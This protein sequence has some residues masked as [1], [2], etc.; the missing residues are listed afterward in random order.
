[1]NPRMVRHSL[2]TGTVGMELCALFNSACSTLIR[3]PPPG[4]SIECRS[5]RRPLRCFSKPSWHDPL[6]LHVRLQ[7]L[8]HQHAPVGLLI[9][10]ENRQ[11]STPDGQTTAVQSVHELRFGLSLPAEAYLGP[12][13]LKSFEIRAR[14]NLAVQLLSGKPDL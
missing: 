14:G 4:G 7:S 11:P 3:K 13:S 1:M 6:S 8:R 5:F 12:P 2:M 9:I 10:F